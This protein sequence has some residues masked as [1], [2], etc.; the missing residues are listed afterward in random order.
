MPR[1]ACAA[2]SL[3][4]FNAPAWGQLPLTPQQVKTFSPLLNDSFKTDPLSC[5]VE[6][7]RPFFD[8]SFRYEIGYIVEC[9]LNQFGGQAGTLGTVLRIT[10]VSG[11][12]TVL[13]QSFDI[14]APP[15]ESKGK[16]NIKHL[17]ANLEFSGFVSAGEGEY[18]VD[19]VVVDGH[20]RCFRKHWHAKAHAQGSEAQAAAAMPPNTVAAVSL[21]NWNG[22]S[23]DG[24]G[25]RLTVLLD[26]APINPYALKLRAWDRAFL[27]GSVASL[28]RQVPVAS[29][30]LVA[31]NLDQQQEIYRDDDFDRTGIYRLAGA[32]NRLELGTISYRTLQRAEGSGELLAGLVRAEALREHP[33]D[34]VVFVGPTLRLDRKI[35]PELLSTQSHAETPFFYLEYCPIIGREFPDSIQHV[36]S[37]RNGVT[38]KLHSPGDLAHAI[39][40]M[41]KMLVVVQ[42]GG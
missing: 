32:L 21:P 27:L 33:A 40:K 39:T 6:T 17:R 8:F 18:E 42:P 12:S 31:F 29:V 38:F 30:R 41:Q 24:T 13:G 19:L 25:L 3:A 36:I 26:A 28:L 1:L 37:A 22:T 5:H 16:L 4:L 7:L 34:A 14:P 23:D 10:P 2:L 35:A 20:R 9:P 11:A 15:P